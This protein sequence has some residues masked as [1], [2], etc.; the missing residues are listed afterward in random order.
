[1]C[2]P[3]RG[4]AAIGAR[5]NNSNATIHGRRSAGQQEKRDRVAAACAA[6]VKR[7]LQKANYLARK[8]K[9]D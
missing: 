9:Q 3:N 8:R 4:A 2:P 6:R 5:L 7:A 1:M